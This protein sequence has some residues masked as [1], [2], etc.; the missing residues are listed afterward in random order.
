MIWLLYVPINLL[1]MLV[2]YITNPIVVLFAT[3][4]GELK[5]FLNYWQTHDDSLDPAFFVKEKVPAF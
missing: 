5:G 4:T 3:E 1:I 2:C